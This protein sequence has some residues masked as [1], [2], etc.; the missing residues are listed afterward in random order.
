MTIR[1]A[2]WNI[3]AAL[4]ARSA[5]AHDYEDH[6][7][8]EY[9]A[10]QLRLVDADVICL[11]ATQMNEDDSM[12]Q[13]LAK[14]LG[15]QFIDETIGFPSYFDPLDNL[16]IA[17]LSKQPF[18]N[19]MAVKL[20]KPEFPLVSQAS[21]KTAMPAD[22]YLQIVDFD[23][24]KIANVWLEPLSPYGYNYLDGE[25]AAFATALD[26]T[27]SNKLQQ[28]LLFAA[29]F[30]C[31]DPL[32][33]LPQVAANFQLSEALPDEPTKLNGK[34]SDHILYSPEWHSVDAGVIKTQSDHFLCWAEFEK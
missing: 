7:S 5:K 24:F 27:M 22:R 28:P 29:D 33:A 25:G 10:D 6:E 1:I 2:T 23:E 34:P 9:F 17:V 14:M 4:K 18:A 30:N 15:M 19:T 12:A 26:T 32:A 21:G 13:R 31:P 20:P 11:Q 16:N 8:L 3:T